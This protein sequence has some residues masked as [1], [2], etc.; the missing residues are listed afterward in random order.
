MRRWDV[1]KM[2]KDKDN[3]KEETTTA[4]LSISTSHL[5]IF[6]K[7]G[8]MFKK[9]VLAVAFAVVAASVSFAEVAISGRW[10]Q[11]LGSTDFDF[12]S[13]EVPDNKSDADAGV[14]GI[15]LYMGSGG[16]FDLDEN[17][18][19]GLK[20]GYSQL[21]KNHLSSSKLKLVSD[22]YAGTGNVYIKFKLHEMFAVS[23]SAGI[24]AAYSSYEYKLHSLSGSKKKTGDGWQIMPN[25]SGAAEFRPIDFF[26]VGF[27]VG[28]MFNGKF[29]YDDFEIKEAKIY[30][31]I[32][33]FN[34]NFFVKLYLPKSKE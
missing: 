22:V 4:P 33:G 1:G 2:S 14:W 34:Y 8:T 18:T 23:G 10:G 21:G 27:E 24:F 19:L 30:R 29:N 3:D 17:I 9:L 25:I 26:A 16:A 5:L 11:I 20:L 12:N 7:G 13:V 28:Y 31:D 6:Y 32:S 15:D